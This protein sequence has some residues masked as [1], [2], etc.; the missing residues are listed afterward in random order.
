MAPTLTFR[1]AARTVTGSRHLLEFGKKKVLVD[2]GLFQGPRE[3]RELNWNPFTFDPS[4]IDAVVLTHAHTDHAGLLPRL[5]A[6]GYRGPIYA[7]P[8]SVSIA[9]I[10]LPDGGRI[11]E[12]DARYRNK[13]QLTRHQPALPLF[14]EADARKALKQFQKVHY[15]QFQE[16]P[17]KAT[18]RFFPAGHILGSAMVELYFESGERVLF[19]GDLGRYDRP[20]IKD[21]YPANFAEYLVLESTYGDRLHNNVDVKARLEELTNQV[22]ER[23]STLLVPSFAIGRTQELLWYLHELKQE[24]RLPKMPIYVDSPMATAATLLYV[25]HDEDHDQDMRLNLKEGQSPLKGDWVHFVRDRHMSKQLNDARGPMIVIAGSGMLTGG[26]ILHHLLH[27]ARD[28]ENVLLFTGYQAHGTLGRKILDGEREIFV[29]KYPVEVNC[30][31]DRLDMLSAHADAREI[32]R[33]LGNFKSPPKKTYLVH[34]EI[35]SQEALQ[36]SIQ[37]GLGWDVEIPEYGDQ[38]SLATS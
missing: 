28:P 32:M 18:F 5:V 34:G 23:G 9:R 6:Q 13:N 8:G 35:E 29:H 4:E 27:K 15:F 14:T 37:K 7:T 1:G 26:R 22:A 10:S 17:G 12:E 38:V 3:I 21:P 24:G 2:C 31:I 11:Q 36:A 25:E 30:Q 33:W 16:L 19:S 20:I